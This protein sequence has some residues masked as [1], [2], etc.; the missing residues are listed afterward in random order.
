MPPR[1][2]VG[3]PDLMHE[4]LRGLPASARVLDI[5]SREGSFEA[6]QYPF[7][8]VRVDL[9]PHPGGVQADATS[10]PFG[11]ACFDASAQLAS[12][13]A[14]SNRTEPCTLPYPTRAV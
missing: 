14:W 12:S 6:S 1:A 7:Q 8:T 9:D 11:S 2:G 5:G 13:A 4:I 3:Y 10:L